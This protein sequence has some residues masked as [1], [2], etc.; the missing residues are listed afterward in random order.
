MKAGT[1][2][3]DYLKKISNGNQSFVQQMVRSFAESVEESVAEIETKLA[4]GDRKGIGESAH[5]LKFSLGVMGVTALNETVAFLENQGKQME[6][7][8]PRTAY[9]QTVSGFIIDMKSLKHQA[10]EILSKG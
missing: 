5:K 4:R 1:I 2:Q 3:L 9:D 10:E 6:S 8:A 7:P